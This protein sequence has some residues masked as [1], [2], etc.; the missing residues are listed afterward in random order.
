MF[1]S[2]NFAS[3]D[4]TVKNHADSPVGAKDHEFVFL[5]QHGHGIRP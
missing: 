1:E 3:P 4:E 2:V 5:T